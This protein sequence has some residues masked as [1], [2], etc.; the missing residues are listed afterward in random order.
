[1]STKVKFLV[2][3]VLL[4]ESACRTSSSNES[5]LFGAR[6]STEESPAR[7][8]A[9]RPRIVQILAN[10]SIV[11]FGVR[12]CAN[13][14]PLRANLY[15]WDAKGSNDP[16]RGSVTPMLDS[17]D[18]SYRLAP[19]QIDLT[20]RSIAAHARPRAI[21]TIV[22]DHRRGASAEDSLSLARSTLALLDAEAR[23]IYD[24]SWQEGRSC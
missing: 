8:R 20:W 7:D 4:R 16:Y 12:R 3:S 19:R 1:M 10:V 6:M 21:L 9:I 13:L 23:L 15:P 18:C 17:V 11:R 2:V 24:R 5:R 14:H 22:D